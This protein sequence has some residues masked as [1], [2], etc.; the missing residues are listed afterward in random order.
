[1]AHIKRSKQKLA[2]VYS[3]NP[4]LRGEL[5]KCVIESESIRT[6]ETNWAS[7]IEKYDLK[8]STWL[9][10]LFNIRQRWV[11]VYL[12]DIFFA[13]MSSKQKL[14]TMNDFYKKYFNTKTSLKV[15]L[16]QFDLTMVERYEDEVQADLDTTCTKP[17]LKTA[18]PI[19]KQAA[20]V[21]TRAVFEKFQEEFVESL[22]YNVYKVKDGAIS[23]FH[24]A[25]DD[26]A[27]ETFT[28]TYNAAKCMATT[29]SCKHLEFAG[30]L[31]RHVLGV[32]L[33]VDVRMLPEDYFLKR[34]TTNANGGS[35][36]DERSTSSQGSYLDSISSRF[37]DLCRDALKYAE[38]GATSAEIYKAAKV[39]LQKVFTEI[40]ANEKHV[41]RGSLRD[42]IN[43]NE[44]ITIDDAMNDQSLHDQTLRDPERKGMLMKL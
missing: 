37:S 10:G 29:C 14:E 22:G 27:L 13:E 25:R 35:L 23:K 11:P 41:G 20:A 34:W 32:F 38:K 39:A 21:Y 17:I 5:E 2:H 16:T 15:L 36:L 33:M 18:S 3:A 19:E 43:I 1:M 28:V 42:V 30:I 24:V 44:E 26:D 9:Q 40:V 12:K 31:C 6:F 8:K 4:C 7:I